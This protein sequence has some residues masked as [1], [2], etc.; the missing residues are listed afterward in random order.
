MNAIVWLKKYNP[1]IKISLQC[2]LYDI[3]IDE[4][5]DLLR[6][7]QANDL[8]DCLFFLVAMQPN[9]TARSTTGARGRAGFY[10]RKTPEGYCGAGGNHR[11]EEGR[12]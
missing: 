8:V 2:V 11:H 3:N 7:V 1:G 5:V 12:L 4:T 9:N 6:W 10:G